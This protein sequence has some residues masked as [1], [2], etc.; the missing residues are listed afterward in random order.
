MTTTLPPS[1]EDIDAWCS[2]QKV[3][4]HAIRDARTMIGGDVSGG[5]LLVAA[6]TLHNGTSVFLTLTG[7]PLSDPYTA[8]MLDGLRQEF[9]GASLIVRQYNISVPR[10]RTPSP[11]DLVADLAEL[12]KINDSANWA[13]IR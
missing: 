13:S 6:F 5:P 7:N 3:I 10:S 1:V 11:L 4:E 9:G 8:H 12:D 2:E